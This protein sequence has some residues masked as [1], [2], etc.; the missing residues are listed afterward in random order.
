MGQ[1]PKAVERATD[2]DQKIL[3]HAGAVS[4]NYMD[5]VSLATRQAMAGVE[6][7]VSATHGEW[8]VSDVQAFMKDVGNTQCVGPSP[9]IVNLLRCIF[10]RV[11]PTETIYAALPAFMYLNASLIGLLLEPMLQ[12][13]NSSE[14]NNPY[15]APDLGRKYPTAAHNGYSVRI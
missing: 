9:E 12:F 13:Q 5:L 4:R 7:T 11:N 1:F 15:A 8:D 10:K 14:Y 3:Q 2:L 6:I